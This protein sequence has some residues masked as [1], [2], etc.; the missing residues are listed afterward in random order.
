MGRRLG[1]DNSIV[2]FVY[3]V[4]AG[5]IRIL[6][7]SGIV[8]RK[9]Q[10]V[11][12]YHGVKPEQRVGF[13]RQM[14]HIEKILKNK[15]RPDVFVT[16]DDGFRNLI[17]NAADIINSCRIPAAFFIVPGYLGKRPG[18]DISEEHEDYN[19]VMMTSE[20]IINVQ[21]DFIS[22]GSHTNNHLKLAEI[23][24]NELEK[25]LIES[26]RF[27]EQLLGKTVDEIALPHGIFNEKVIR[28]A[29]DS[30]YRKIYSLESRLNKK[31]E[32]SVLL[33]RFSVS[34]DMSFTEF[35]LI[36]CGAYFWLHSFR[37]FINRKR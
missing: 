2:N 27:L 9:R 30:G 1:K 14:K 4:I 24:D 16:F 29:I 12:C 15:N 36:C 33:G 5:V 10:V 23:S 11:L 3:L 8:F 18:W 28:K 34:P 32:D 17:D 19:E 21:S 26:K 25:E 13:G 31:D 20:E 35:R 22:I 6:T 7:F 37:R